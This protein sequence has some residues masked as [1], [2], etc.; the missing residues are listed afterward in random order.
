MEAMYLS[1]LI[2][3]GIDHKIRYK[4]VLYL[5]Q[6]ELGMD[7]DET[8]ELVSRIDPSTKYIS[9]ILSQIRQKNIRGYEDAPRAKEAL[10][11]FDKI[12]KSSKAKF[13]KDINKYKT[14]ADLEDAIS[15]YIEQVEVDDVVQN[16]EELPGVKAIGTF[17]DLKI[18]EV[19]NPT[20]LGIL[21]RGT[22]WCTREGYDVD[23][24]TAK[25]YLKSGPIYNIRKNS[26]PYA[27]ITHDF[28]QVMDINDRD[29]KDDE[30][31]IHLAKYINNPIAYANLAI[32][33]KKRLPEY[34]SI[35]RISPKAIRIYASKDNVYGDPG[36]FNGRWKSA[37]ARLFKNPIE[38]YKYWQDHFN[39]EPWPEAERTFSR[40]GYVS[41][42]YLART[43]RLTKELVSKILRS[44][45]GIST[46]AGLVKPKYKNIFPIGRWK[47]FE[48][49]LN[50]AQDILNYLEGIAPTRAQDLEQRLIKEFSNH[51]IEGNSLYGFYKYFDKYNPEIS[52]YLTI[53]LIKNNKIDLI[54]ENLSGTIRSIPY[55]NYLIGNNDFK[56]LLDYLD[57][58]D[59]LKSI[60]KK[61]EDLLKKVKPIIDQIDKIPDSHVFDFTRILDEIGPNDWTLALSK[62]HNVLPASF[63]AAGANIEDPSDLESNSLYSYVYQHGR[64][65]KDQEQKI[66][67]DPKKLENYLSA[68]ADKDEYSAE[69]LKFIR[70][71]P[72]LISH[73][74]ETW[75]SKTIQHKNAYNFLML[76]P[77]L[78]NELYVY[79]IDGIINFFNLPVNKFDVPFLITNRITNRTKNWLI[80]FSAKIE[81][82]DKNFY[83][84]IRPNF[85]EHFVSYLNKHFPSIDYLMGLKSFDEMPIAVDEKQPDV[86]KKPTRHKTFK[87]SRDDQEMI[88]NI[89][90]NRKIPL[91]IAAVENN[92]ENITI[93]YDFF[94]TVQPDELNGHQQ[95]RLYRIMNMYPFTKYTAWIKH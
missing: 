35:I 76:Y 56:R 38:T 85:S 66:W 30:L 62:K 26:K 51:F 32:K 21:G 29:L 36:L 52:D 11:N 95:A 44:S 71:K 19:T 34:E 43:D 46:M 27:Q 17:K 81:P 73:L 48:H 82:Q 79:S 47:K 55:E 28:D 77:N 24:I 57:N 92:P 69:E 15:P 6:T 94:K 40:N 22:K 67:K 53:K 83:Q 64:V 3:E 5:I 93:F 25:S 84:K 41:A 61:E 2:L 65:T 16:P 86:S 1:D 80:R 74:L 18:Y 42:K 75:S 59:N 45:S 50:N 60:L 70:G 72:D 87:I 91:A 12:K 8:L 10:D 4:K 14:L 54:E 68:L 58:L 39:G 13:D 31:I 20:S 33:L 9:W 63:I 78:S 88:Q 49:L 37:E 90:N 89:I 7:P 23:G